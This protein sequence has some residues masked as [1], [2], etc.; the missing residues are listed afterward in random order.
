MPGTKDP[1][2]EFPGSASDP[3]RPGNPGSPPCPGGPGG[4]GGPGDLRLAISWIDL[5]AAARSAIPGIMNLPDI[6]H[7][8]LSD[9]GSTFLLSV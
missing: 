1:G 4:P 8:P 3:G 5:R 2:G 9:T 6:R 7:S